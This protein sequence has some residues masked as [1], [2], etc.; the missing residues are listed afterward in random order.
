MQINRPNGHLH[1]ARLDSGNVDQVGEKIVQ[2]RRLLI[3]FANEFLLLFCIFKM[4]VEQGFQITEQSKNRRAQ[5]W[6]TI[7]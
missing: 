1:L 5:S 7:A 4:A 6:E 2:S 3:G